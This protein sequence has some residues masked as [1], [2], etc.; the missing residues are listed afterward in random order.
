MST[1]PNKNRPP[2]TVRLLV[3]RGDYIA[4]RTTAIPRRLKMVKRTTGAEYD[5]NF[6]SVETVISMKAFKQRRSGAA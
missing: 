5:P 2:I 3:V 1:P 4:R 6:W